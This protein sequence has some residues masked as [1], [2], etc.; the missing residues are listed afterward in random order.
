M[1]IFSPPECVTAVDSSVMDHLTFS[2]NLALGSSIVSSKGAAGP[3]T[4]SDPFSLDTADGLI[5]YSVRY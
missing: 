5:R 4:V 1:L 3:V 2:I